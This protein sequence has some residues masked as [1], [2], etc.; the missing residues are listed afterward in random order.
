M[1]LTSI[2]NIAM[3]IFCTLALSCCGNA[4]P[5]NFNALWDLS[6]DQRQMQESLFAGAQLFQDPDYAKRMDISRANDPSLSV[7]IDAFKARGGTGVWITQVAHLFRVDEVLARSRSQQSAAGQPVI[8]SFVVYNLPDRDCAAGASAGELTLKERGMERYKSEF[9]DVLA[10]KFHDYPDVRIAIVLEPDSLPNAVTNRGSGR[11]TD[12]VLQGYRTGVVYA[13]KRLASA[14][15]AL[16]LD[17]AHSG[18]M[19]WDANRSGLAKV[20]REVL[21]AAGGEG[22]VRGFATN[23]SNYT[24]LVE[25][26]PSDQRRQ[27]PYYSSN[28]AMDELSYV[29]L[30]AASLEGVG[31]TRHN[32]IIDTG[33]NGNPRARTNWGSW[34]N[35]AKAKIGALPTVDPAPALPIAPAHLDAYM[36]IKPPGESDGS[37]S[38]G[39]SMEN[40]PG[41]GMWFHE[42]FKAMITE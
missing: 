31:I 32:F 25:P 28:P 14:H 9:I 23:V 27:S 30:L 20:F 16:Y 15:V 4:H 22:M 13:I 26:D 6:A 29:R 7:R 2:H 39:D 8:A 24:P 10:Q 40:A 17:A 35:V 36:W 33:R 38:G 5:E 21:D 42:H 34:C 12:E 19:G 1:R 37:C 41:A 18:W 11:C 3:G